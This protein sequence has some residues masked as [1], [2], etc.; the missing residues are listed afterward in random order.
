MISFLLHPA[1]LTSSFLLLHVY[2]QGKHPS[3]QPTLSQSSFIPTPFPSIHH[4]PVA[5][6]PWSFSLWLF[7]SLCWPRPHH[8]KLS[9][10]HTLWQ[11]CMQ[12]CSLSSSP[13]LL[14]QTLLST[15]TRSLGPSALPTSPKPPSSYKPQWPPTPSN[16]PCAPHLPGHTAGSSLLALPA[17]RKSDMTRWSARKYEWREGGLPWAL[18]EKHTHTLPYKFLSQPAGLRGSQAEIRGRFPLE[19]K[20]KADKMADTL[21]ESVVGFIL[22]RTTVP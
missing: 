15:L 18:R 19:K 4:K 22:C 2:L 7:I 5:M 12:S 13:L 17:C 20:I 14:P 11:P 9:H 16:A 1:L 6:L 10:H 3:P 21:M 8:L